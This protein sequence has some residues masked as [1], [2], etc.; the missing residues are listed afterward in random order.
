MDEVFKLFKSSQSQHMDVDTGILSECISKALKATDIQIINWNIDPIYCKSTNF[1]TGGIYRVHGI[2]GT[3]QSHLPW[4]IIL[5]V[6]QSEQEDK[7]HFQHHNYWKREALVNE[8]GILMHLPNVIQTPECYKVEQ[9]SESEIWLWMEEIKED[10]QN[11]WSEDKFKFIAQQLGLFHGAYATG[12]Q[13]L[14]D[15]EW[16]CRHWLQSWIAGCEKYTRDPYLDYPKI[17]GELQEFDQ[18]WDT[19]LNLN[20]NREIHFSAINLLPKALSHQ[21]LSKQNMYI[22]TEKEGHKNLILIDWQFLSISGIGEDLG[23]LFGIAL[24]QEDIP[25]EQGWYYQSLIFKSYMEGLIK[26]GWKGEESLPRYG[27]CISV[28]FRSSWEVPRLIQL[29]ANTNIDSSTSMNKDIYKL[30]QIVRIQMKLAEE[31]QQILR[32]MGNSLFD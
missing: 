26:A 5:K 11:K 2:A 10:N 14:P 32:T 6:I 16:I 25:T 23:K 24:S 1:T 12:E 7:N 13:P 27:F 9:K 8:L 3:G 29:I 21:D 30:L 20:Q 17:Q 22:S 15:E 18:I 4:T 19:F 31:A 28:A